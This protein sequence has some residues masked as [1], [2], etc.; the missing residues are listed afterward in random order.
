MVGPLGVDLDLV[1]SVIARTLRDVNYQSKLI[2]L[3][4]LLNTISGF[5]TKLVASP[6]D[7]R[8]E[9]HMKVGTELR[10]RTKWPD[11]LAL[12]AVARIR[13]ERQQATGDST[14]PADR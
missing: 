6:E 3:S 11:F 7:K 13:Q 10:T 14:R 2:R 12:L 4:G 5:A 9:S 1:A 8:I